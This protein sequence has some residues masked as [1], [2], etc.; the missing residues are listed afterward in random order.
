MCSLRG[1]PRGNA[2]RTLEHQ[3]VQD[4]GGA[5]VHQVWAEHFPGPGRSGGVRASRV[6]ARG[7][8][9]CCQLPGGPLSLPRR[10]LSR[11]RT[12]RRVAQP[13]RAGRRPVPGRISPVPDNWPAPKWPETTVVAAIGLLIFRRRIRWLVRVTRAGRLGPDS[14]AVHC[15]T[16]P[17][18]K[19]SGVVVEE[20]DDRHRTGS[21][22]ASAMHGRCNL[23]LKREE[24]LCGAPFVH[25]LVSFGSFFQGKREVE[26]LPWV[27]LAVPD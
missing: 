14:S 6:A 25:R 10:L 19:L 9:G 11:R 24:Y 22:T 1:C 20:F 3:R 17:M 18:M 7:P 4:R 15:H 16:S 2:D 27:N 13:L 21:A 8:M 23:A 5:A 26:D 12:L